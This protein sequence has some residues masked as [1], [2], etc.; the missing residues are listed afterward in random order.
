MP[1]GRYNAYRQVS[2]T[3]AS[4]AEVVGL[5]DIVIVDSPTSAAP[6]MNVMMLVRVVG[7]TSYCE[8]VR[9]A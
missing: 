3:A 9:R 5:S 1:I 2:V 6:S 8:L 7:L 4:Y